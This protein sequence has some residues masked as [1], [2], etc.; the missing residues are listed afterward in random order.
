MRKF[1]VILIIFLGIAFVYLSFGE[2]QSIVKTLQRGNIWFVL[3][4]ILIQFSWFL[5][6]GLTY[7]SLYRVLGMDGTAYK[8][9]LMS[10]A[11]SFVNI[12][13]P[14]AGMGGMAVFISNARRN[15]QSPGK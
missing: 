4:A 13:A 7:L 9:S 5:G 11:A 8:M 2:I 10:A 3:L 15:G 12:V 1:I 14:T 6:T